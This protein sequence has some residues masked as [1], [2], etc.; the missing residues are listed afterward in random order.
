M[1]TL[2]KS[3]YTR[4]MQCQK[5][6]WMDTYKLEEAAEL[7]KESIMKTGNEVGDCGDDPE[8]DYHALEGVH[9]GGETMDAFPAMASMIPEEVAVKRKQLLFYC[10]L[11]TLAMVIVLEKLY[12]TQK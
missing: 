1:T 8:L 3:K 11:D 7:N 10:R 6:L 12:D 2:S 4:A 9:N 5:M